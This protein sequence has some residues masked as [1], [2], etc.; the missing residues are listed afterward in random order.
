MGLSRNPAVGYVAPFL[1]FVGVMGIEHLLAPSQIYYPIR[2]LL[3]LA[4]MLA[5]SRPYINLKPT[6]PLA[7]LGIG[8][9]VFLIWIGPDV[10]FGPGYRHFWLFENSIFGKTSSTIDPALKNNPGFLAIRLLGS[11][12]IVPIIE[13]LFWRGWMMRWL[14]SQPFDK[15]PLGTY[16]AGAFWIVAVLFASEH[17]PYWE[18]GLAA[19]AIYNW[20]LVRTRNLADCIW[21]HAITNFVLGVYVLAAGAWQ[22]WM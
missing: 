19:G 3:T 6:F 12:C 17:G 15:I 13:E 4:V 16:R 7:T 2:C 11:A 14:I 20:W 18:V 9:A 10:L 1:T 22:Y 21:A 5:V 8:I